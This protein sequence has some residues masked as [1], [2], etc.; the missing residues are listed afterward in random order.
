MGRW[1]LLL[2]TAE[3]KFIRP[4]NKSHAKAGPDTSKGFERKRKHQDSNLDT[5]VEDRIVKDPYPELN[6]QNICNVERKRYHH[7]QG[8]RTRACR[9]AV[10]I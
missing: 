6:Q 2:C 7:N 1:E 10:P 3:T 8:S 4:Y 9:F 5:K